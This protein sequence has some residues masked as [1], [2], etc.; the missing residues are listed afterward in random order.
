[1]LVLQY[2][3]AILQIELGELSDAVPVLQSC[4]KALETL[5]NSLLHQ[6]YTSHTSSHTSH[7]SGGKKIKEV[8]K[9][10]QGERIQAMTIVLRLLI[11]ATY[12]LALCH[13]RLEEYDVALSLY[14][15]TYQLFNK[16]IFNDALTRAMTSDSSSNT[17]SSVF[18]SLM[19][20]NFYEVLLSS[21]L[22]M[23]DI[24]LLKHESALALDVLML[25]YRLFVSKGYQS[26]LTLSSFYYYQHILWK[27]F[28][29][30]NE[31]C[32]ITL[33]MSVQ[34]LLESVTVEW[35][36]L[37]AGKGGH[38]TS[39]VPAPPS[40]PGRSSEVARQRKNNQ[41]LFSV[42]CKLLVE[43]MFRGEMMDYVIQLL[44]M[45]QKQIHEDNALRYQCKSIL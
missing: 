36:E 22:S 6:N 15:K 41:K 23:Y 14:Q 5:L 43:I 25:V 13:Y 21:L 18:L 19:S 11:P 37:M 8:E 7:S 33:P 24:Y 3:L 40:S 12:Q 39:A 20:Q 31:L 34:A 28:C 35:N 42:A 29:K 9:E 16:I 27:L 45:I 26:Y 44:Q 10:V 2:K 38:D 17:S 4:S 1:M 32:V 30:M